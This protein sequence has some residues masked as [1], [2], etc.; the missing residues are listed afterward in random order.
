LT[1]PLVGMLFMMLFLPFAGRLSDRVGRRP[2]WRFSLIGLLLLVTP[3]YMLMGTGLA[4]ACIGFILLG[5]LYVPQLATISATFPAMFPTSVR[6]VGFASAYNIST[7]IFGG[8]APAVSSGLITL[9]GNDLMP[10]YYM[11]AT[12]VIGLIALHFM[13]ETAGRSLYE[14]PFSQPSFRG[15]AS[16]LRA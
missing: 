6:F 1:V 11:M 5:L 13:P 14:D 16:R 8:T 12:C 3:L 2:M 9:T 7:S 10:A 15:E 4:G